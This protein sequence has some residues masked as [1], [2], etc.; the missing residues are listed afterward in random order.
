MEIKLLKTIEEY[1][2]LTIH[3]LSEHLNQNSLQTLSQIAHIR[4]IA[5]DLIKS[6]NGKYQLSNQ[7]NWLNQEKLKTSL[8]AN[9]HPLVILDSIPSTNSY[10]LENINTLADKT[11]ISC[12][13]QYAGRGRFERRWLSTIAHDLTVSFVY[14]FERDINIL[15]LPLVSAIAVNRLLKNQSIKNKIKWPNDIYVDQQKVA[16]ILVESRISSDKSKVVIGVGLDNFKNWERNQLLIDLAAV[17]DN[18]I[19]EFVLFGFA[20]IRREWLDNCI[21]LNEEVS[22]IENGSEIAR[23]IHHDIGTNGELIIKTQNQLQSYSSS[24]ISLKTK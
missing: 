14:H 12:D 15:L 24:L 22:L 8:A 16:G 13:W 18:I 4:E 20:L 2:S 11:I 19:S 17:L 21:H 5:P 1:T 6:D 10:A 23:G 9:N 7:L 3:E